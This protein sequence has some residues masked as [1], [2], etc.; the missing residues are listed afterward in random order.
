[1]R[2]SQ[3]DATLGSSSRQGERGL[4]IGADDAAR[5]RLGQTEVENLDLAVLV[6]LDVGRLQITMHDAALVSCI[7]AIGDLTEEVDRVVD[8][9]RSSGESLSQGLSLDQLHDDVAQ[10]PHHATG[11]AG[12]LQLDRGAGE[13][14]DDRDVGMVQRGQR[15]RFALEPPDGHAIGD[16]ALGQDLDRH[17]AVQGLVMSPIDLTHATLPELAGDSVWP[18]PIP[19][20]EEHARIVT[21]FRRAPA[22]DGAS[23]GR[24][25]SP[26]PEHHQCRSA[27]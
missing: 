5:D 3:D 11:L 6:D 7:Q 8:A 12:P 26:H 15:L 22:P 27:S 25:Q 2:S 1:M 19:C 4:D 9:Q 17:S 14:V 21:S 24:L 18:E 20:L 13:P 23:G 10:L 16:Q